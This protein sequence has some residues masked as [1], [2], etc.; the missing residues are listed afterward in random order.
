M[1]ETSCRLAAKV[2]EKNML[3]VRSQLELEQRL[4]PEG[5]KIWAALGKPY[6]VC[7]PAALLSTRAAPGHFVMVELQVSLF[8][9]LPPKQHAHPT[10]S[11]HSLIFDADVLRLLWG[12]RV[13]SGKKENVHFSLLN[14]TTFVCALLMRPRTIGNG[15]SPC[16]P[17][18][19]ANEELMETAKSMKIEVNE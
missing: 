4:A 14:L 9:G 6:P 2:R 12:Q 16:K 8:G 17:E 10:I 18:K 19:D 11:A 3:N 7:D 15:E 5:D 1:Q 13:C